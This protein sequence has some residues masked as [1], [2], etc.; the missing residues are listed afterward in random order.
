MGP[1]LG[2]PGRYGPHLRTPFVT[3]VALGTAAVLALPS[4]VAWLGGAVASFAVIL[5][6]A[7]LLGSVVEPRASV[8]WLLLGAVLATLATGAGALLALLVRAI[9]S[10]RL[11]GGS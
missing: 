9:A 6:F 8:R 10:G 7:C 11:D 4:L 2:S 3:G 5:W 1:S